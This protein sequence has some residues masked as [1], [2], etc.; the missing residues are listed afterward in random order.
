[1]SAPLIERRIG[2]AGALVAT[3]LLVEIAVSSWVH[4]MAFVSFAVVACPLVVAGMMLF[5]WALV[6][7]R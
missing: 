4:P 5:L 7:A 6:A 2:W 1:M 3:G